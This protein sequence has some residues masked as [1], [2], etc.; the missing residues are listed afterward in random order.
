MRKGERGPSLVAL[1][2]THTHPGRMNRFFFFLLLDAGKAG[3][4]L[5]LPVAGTVLGTR[6]LGRERGQG[7]SAP[8]LCA[9]LTSAALCHEGGGQAR[10]PP[11]ANWRHRAQRLA[12]PRPQSGRGMDR[13]RPRDRVL[14]SSLP[15]PSAPPPPRLMPGLPASASC[16]ASFPPRSPPVTASS[17]CVGRRAVL[18][19][20][21]T[22]PGRGLVGGEARQRPRG[23]RR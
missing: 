13:A 4:C 7:G 6:H 14:F 1:C 16:S 5:H 19:H 18:G 8:P 12:C 9:R 21:F 17:L 10:L 22:P 11:L 3:S 20:T 15:A 23:P 2:G